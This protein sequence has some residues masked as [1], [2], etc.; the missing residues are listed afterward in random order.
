M[1]RPMAANEYPGWRT[2][3]HTDPVTGAEI[4]IAYVAG[5]VISGT[6]E[7]PVPSLETA[8]ELSPPDR[9]RAFRLRF[10]IHR[11]LA[12]ANLPGYASCPIKFRIDADKPMTVY[13]ACDFN[14][15]FEFN[16]F[17]RFD[18]FVER[19]KTGK[20]LRLEMPIIVQPEY[21]QL[22]VEYPLEGAGDA[23]TQA[24]QMCALATL[25]TDAKMN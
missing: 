14:R 20:H 10:R 22:V 5:A 3:S 2:R 18:A 13:C 6:H 16:N 12:Q 15:Q 24:Q 23:L 11:M 25:A 21:R 17:G 4:L 8:C 9:Q 7:K 1:R 19:M